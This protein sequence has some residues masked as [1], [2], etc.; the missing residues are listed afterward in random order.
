MDLTS[1]V[2]ALAIDP[3]NPATL[4]AGTAG[5]GVFQSTDAGASWTAMN[6]GLTSSSV[7][8]LAIDRSTPTR[9][10][11]ATDAGVYEYRILAPGGHKPIRVIPP[12][13]NLILNSTPTRTPTRT[14]PTRTPT[15]TATPKPT[16]TPVNPCG[17][18]WDYGAKRGVNRREEAGQGWAATSPAGLM[19][20]GRPPA[21][22]RS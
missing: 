22:A 5:S 6:A 4:Y 17:G 12:F 13:P 1:T 19:L 9:I 20:R 7:Y 3:V 10:Y 15:P 11:A 14:T 8:A 21:R 2:L 18:C 16:G